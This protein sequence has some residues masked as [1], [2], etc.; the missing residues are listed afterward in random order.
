MS[1]KTG[2]CVGGPPTNKSPPRA[3]WLCSVDGGLG[4]RAGR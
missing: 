3:L 1:L 4:I 2:L